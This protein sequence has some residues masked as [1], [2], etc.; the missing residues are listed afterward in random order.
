LIDGDLSLP[1]YKIPIGPT[2]CRGHN[3]DLNGKLVDG[4]EHSGEA[5]NT[6]YQT[7]LTYCPPEQS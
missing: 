5:A 3:H 6:K 1:D 4:E 2:T 7:L